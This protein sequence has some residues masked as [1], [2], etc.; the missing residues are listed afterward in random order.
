[1]RRR[2]YT[3]ATPE[4]WPRQIQLL[5]GGRLWNFQYVPGVAPRR[6]GKGWEG[7]VTDLHAYRRRLLKRSRAQRRRDRWIFGRHKRYWVQPEVFAAV[8]MRY[9]KWRD[10]GY[11]EADPEVPALCQKF[12]QLGIVPLWSCEGHQDEEFHPDHWRGF[13]W[14]WA[15]NQQ[16]ANDLQLWMDRWIELMWEQVQPLY[17][18]IAKGHMFQ[19]AG[20]E[21]HL[22]ED[23]KQFPIW[24]LYID[25]L[26]DPQYKPAVIQTMHQ[27][28]DE[29]LAVPMA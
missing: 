25:G 13:Y 12:V 23:V 15:V 2:R 4:V 24:G 5:P 18:K 14:I 16:S 10:A 1:M 20:K 28:L 6:D 3:H 22:P 8:L 21:W 19:Q 9:E 17:S 26:N 7:Y 27:A 29:L 11:P